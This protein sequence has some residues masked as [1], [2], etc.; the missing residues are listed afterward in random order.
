MT[1]QGDDTYKL[2]ISNDYQRDI[3]GR[4]RI[5]VEDMYG[6]QLFAFS[7]SV[8]VKSNSCYNFQKNVAINLSD[9]N[10][11]ECYARIIFMEDDTIL[12]ERL[13]FFT[14]PKDMKLV[15]TELEPKV[16]YNDGKYHLE[17]NSDVFVKDVYVSASAPGDFSDNFFCLLPN[18]TNA[19]VFEPEDKNKKDIKFKVHV[20]NR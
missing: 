6:N 1:D 14:Y 10:K 18:A 16:T 15:K 5:I 2:W 7:E 3:N 11:S 9:K 13:H 17:F 19:I 20:Y 12:S 8:D 4:V